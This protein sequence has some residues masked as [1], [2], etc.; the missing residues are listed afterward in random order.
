MSAI[1]RGRGGGGGRL[2]FEEVPRPEIRCR[3]YLSSM[4]KFAHVLS[5]PVLS[6]PD[7]MR[8]FSYY[9]YIVHT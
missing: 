6:T 2:D 8:Y 4:E 9:L 1:C 5:D 3:Q 7:M